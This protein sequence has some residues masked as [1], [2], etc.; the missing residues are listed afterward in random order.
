MVND[1]TDALDFR[2]SC[3]VHFIDLPKAFLAQL[4][5]SPWQIDST[6]Q[7]DLGML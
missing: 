3:A 4:T 2:T 5:T 1:V 6:V 7:A